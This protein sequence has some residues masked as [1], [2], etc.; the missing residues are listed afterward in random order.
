MFAAFECYI[1][2]YI[3]YTNKL[4]W[5]FTA[6]ELL[7][8]SVNSKRSWSY[9]RYLIPLAKL[10]CWSILYHFIVCLKMMN[11]RMNANNKMPI[12]IN[13]TMSKSPVKH[14][15][16]KFKCL[17]LRVSDFLIS[18]NKKTKTKIFFLPLLIFK[19]R[20]Q[21]QQQHHQPKNLST[22]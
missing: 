5:L 14:I 9:I 19:N 22:N 12:Q 3:M 18:K 2:I 17:N 4:W 6:W 7:W 15:I 10:K 1:S 21:Q 16:L 11:E 20:K 13:E 8:F